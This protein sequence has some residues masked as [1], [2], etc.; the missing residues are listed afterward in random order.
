M[1]ADPSNDTANTAAAPRAGAPEVTD[2]SGSG[3]EWWRGAVIYQI[4]PRSFFD[5][6]GN[7]V[8]DLPGIWQKLDYVAD[9]GVDGIWI[10]PFFTSPM[11]DFGYDIADFTGVDPLFGTLADFD[12]IITKAHA[13]GLKVIIDQVYSHSS[14]Q[15]PWFQESRASRTN[16][17][18]DW[19]VW[20]DPKPDGTP[21]NNWL[22]VFNGPAWTWDTRR[23]QYFFHNFLPEQ[24]DLNLHNPDVV[25]AIEA[26]A[27]FWLDRGVD[28]FRL[29]AAN[30][31]L[32]DPALPN[33]PASGVRDAVRPRA[34]QQHIYNRSQPEGLAV[35]ERLRR[36]LDAYPDRFSVGE[37]GEQND[38]QE[39]IA[40]TKGPNRLHTAYNFAFIEA[41]HVSARLIR[42]ALAVWQPVAGEAW[43]A[44]TFSNHDRPR[45][46]TRWDGEGDPA[47][48][49]LMAALLFSLRGTL[50]LYQGEE[51]GLPQGD[52]PYERLTDPEAIANWP[53]TIGRD[54]CRTP[55]PWQANAPQAGFST[56]DP[57]LPVDPR[58]PP[59]AVDAQTADPSS[60]LAFVRQFLTRR[61]D[62]PALIR[63]D[64]RLYETAEPLLVFERRL[65]DDR[66]LCVFNLGRSSE[67][68]PLPDA[69]AGPWQRLDGF[70]LTGLIED[71]WVTLGPLTGLIAR[72][73]VSRPA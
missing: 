72:Q 20:A 26:T 63:G 43:P 41:D 51:L 38:H 27:R 5:T 23:R 52:I 37:I 1:P 62:V 11:K 10:S 69:A 6:T 34:F 61:R 32:H 14:D 13:L 31:Y 15:H 66:L 17:K 8:G 45:V 33:N 44:W 40:Y 39:V 48:A 54:G 65:A 16:A 2:R 30:F 58:H 9:L 25:D 19:Y 49:K 29:D 46:V 22:S 7:G 68:R 42:A 73:P 53:E 64:V 24:P 35:I 70:G 57:W 59:L 12:A 4:Y 21:P 47:F 56:G 28:G 3:T 50:F 60:T 55:M 18:A 36:V 71:G 67:N